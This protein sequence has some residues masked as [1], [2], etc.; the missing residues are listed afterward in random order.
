[1][2]E[3]FTLY[4]ILTGSG[5]ERAGN[6]LGWTLRITAGWML[7]SRTYTACT[8]LV[9]YFL[10]LLLSVAC[11][12][13]HLTWSVPILVKEWNYIRIKEAKIR[14]I[15]SK[16]WKSAVVISMHFWSLKILITYE[17]NHHKLLSSL[18]MICLHCKCTTVNC[19]NN[20]SYK[21]Y[22]FMLTHSF[23]CTVLNYEDKI[24]EFKEYKCQKPLSYHVTSPP[25]RFIATWKV[26]VGA[27]PSYS[28][29]QM[30]RWTSTEPGKSI[31]W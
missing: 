9:N 1:M 25:T 30:E 6:T 11:P 20:L 13:L 22:I 15:H 17:L 12:L 24:S 2:S 8:G 5:K 14:Y 31:R 27:G 29:G 4:W 10:V 18:K 23:L 3:Y 7:H 16:L 21:T 26:L 28:Q 19:Q